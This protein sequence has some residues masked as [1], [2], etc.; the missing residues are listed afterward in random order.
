[1]N[2]LQ[3][4]RNETVNE[5]WRVVAGAG[6]RARRRLGLGRLLTRTASQQERPGVC[7]HNVVDTAARATRSTRS[8][9]PDGIVCGVDEPGPDQPADRRAL[10][11]R[12]PGQRCRRRPVHAAQPVRHRQCRPGRRSTTP[13]ARSGEF[14]TYKQDVA[15]A[16]LRGD[17][18]DGFGAGAGQAGHRRRMAARTRRGN[19]RPRQPA[20]VHRLHPAAMGS[21]TAARP[22]CSKATPRLNVPVF[23]DAADRATISSIDGAVRWHAQQEP[24]ARL[25]ANAGESASRDFVDL[26]AQRHLGRDRL[27]AAA[28]H[29]LARRARARS[30]ASCY[31]SYAT[32][33]RRAVRRRSTT[34]SIRRQRQRSRPDID[35]RRRRQPQAREGRHADRAVSS[36]ARTVARYPAFASR[37]TGTQIKI[38][39]AIVGPPFGHRRAEHRHAV[40]SRKTRR[41]A[42]RL[43]SPGPKVHLYDPDMPEADIKTINNLAAQPAGLHHPRHRFRGRLQHRARRRRLVRPAHAL[44]RGSTIRSSP[45][46]AR[47]RPKTTGRL[48]P[49]SRA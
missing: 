23:R 49:A 32:T 29:P 3:S 37:P 7:Y 34:R 30:S 22:K 42:T 26:E 16:N 20:V 44:P 11:G 12:R 28:R 35:H 48:L 24:P 8:R 19:A 2:N 36:V 47:R 33:A 14:S 13:S 21:T 5:T 40:V 38:K 45:P 27:A 18:F 39:D 15:A 46:V 43:C 1:M 31:Q 6:G 4:A 25:G 41:S 17:L 10:F 9:P